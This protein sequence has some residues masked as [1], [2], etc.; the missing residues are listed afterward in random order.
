MKCRMLALTAVLGLV[1]GLGLAQDRKG[2]K[3]AGGPPDMEKAM[4]AMAKHAAPGEAHAAYKPLVGKW[5]YVGKMWMDPTDPNPGMTMEG[6]SEIQMIMDGRFCMNHVK[7]DPPMPFEGR[8]CYGY[9][10]ASKKYW[11]AWIDSMTTSLT[12]AEGTYDARTKTFTFTSEGFDP[13]EGK[14]VKGK[15]TMHIKSNDEIIHT[16]FKMMDGKEVKMME[17]TCKRAK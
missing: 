1:A 12:R 3:K 11:Y 8:G 17:L 5:T 4:A 2:D 16:F 14:V 15:D 10:N 13:M 6:K 9:D 7:G